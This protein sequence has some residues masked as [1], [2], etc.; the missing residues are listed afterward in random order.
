MEVES[1]SQTCDDKA[2]ILN[3]L[4]NQITEATL[5]PTQQIGRV[6]EYVRP[7]VKQHL[8]E[9]HGNPTPTSSPGKYYDTMRIVEEALRRPILRG[10]GH[11]AT[12]P[13]IKYAMNSIEDSDRKHVQDNDFVFHSEVGRG[14]VHQAARGIFVSRSDKILRRVAETAFCMLQYKK[15]R[16]LFCTFWDISQRVR[17]FSEATLDH[18]LG[19]EWRKLDRAAIALVK[20]EELNSGQ[21]LSRYDRH[22][23]TKTQKP[24][25]VHKSLG[26]AVATTAEFAAISIEAMNRVLAEAG[27][28]RNNWYPH[29]FAH[30][31]KISFGAKLPF[32]AAQDFAIAANSP[33]P[34]PLFR[35]GPQWPS[36]HHVQ[37]A[38]DAHQRYID[39]NTTGECQ[40]ILP[41]DP[42]YVT[43]GE[44]RLRERFLSTIRK[45]AQE[46]DHA[47]IAHYDIP[48]ASGV[49]SVDA[50]TALVLGLAY[51]G[52]YNL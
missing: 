33:Y 12:T 1:S 21:K 5:H 18:R 13:L 23:L 27:C 39:N 3:D 8:M 38:K 41:M 7:L 4:Q 6:I 50:A 25:D 51:K 46:S 29:A 49:T 14:R 17:D 48:D 32:W 28:T 43:Y 30:L 36:P 2:N 9:A 45:V 26:N 19:N 20:V 24:L 22:L 47:Y 31:N 16:E 44:A 42:K 34:P 37:Y 40:G 35:V 11:L 52:Q 10:L 15:E